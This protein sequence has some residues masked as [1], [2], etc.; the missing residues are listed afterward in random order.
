MKTAR[1]LHSVKFWP[2]CLAPYKLTF[3]PGEQVFILLDEGEKVLLT[4]RENPTAGETRWVS[5]ELVK[6]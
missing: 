4:M 1:L 3:N 2:D 5:R 6:Q